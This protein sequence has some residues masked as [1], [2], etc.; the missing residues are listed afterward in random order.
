MAN[1]ALLLKAATHR[2][3]LTPILRMDAVFALY[4]IPDGWSY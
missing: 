4:G 1:M 2:I 3:Q